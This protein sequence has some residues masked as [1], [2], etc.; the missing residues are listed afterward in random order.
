[1]RGVELPVKEFVPTLPLPA[2]RDAWLTAA[3]AAELFWAA[4]SADARISDDFRAICS[5]NAS[6]VRKT[7]HG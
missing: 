6:T 5:H 1:V 3:R 7:L 4:A 2:E